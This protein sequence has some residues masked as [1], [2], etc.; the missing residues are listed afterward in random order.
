MADASTDRKYC[1]DCRFCFVPPSG[2]KFA[3]CM[4]E[5]AVDQS[6]DKFVSRQFDGL[7]E[8]QYASTMR[9][10]QCGPAANWFEPKQAEAVAA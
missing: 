3:R 2:I 5:G 8:H 4:A 9:V 6:F 7:E 10:A 1:E